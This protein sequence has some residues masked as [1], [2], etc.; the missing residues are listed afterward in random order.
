MPEGGLETA[1]VLL[2]GG[3]DSSVALA[4]AV[5]QGYRVHALTLDYGQRHSRELEAAT[6]VAAHYGVEHKVVRIDLTAFGGS[7]LTDAAI[8]VPKDTPEGEI[9][10][11]IPPTYVPARNTVFLSLALA[12]A[13]ALDADAIFI[14]ANSVD[15]SGYPDCRPEYLDAMQ[16]VAD[17]GTRRGV[18]GRPV[19]IHAP[20][21]TQS[22][23]AIV[24]RGLELGAPLHLTWT[25]YE[26]GA[27]ACGRC[28]SCQLRL[29]GFAQAGAVDPVE[30]VPGAARPDREATSPTGGEA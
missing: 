6:A 28:E 12:W 11:G 2:S 23:A 4:I 24:S 26:G 15:Y 14:G 22:K 30:Y 25:C 21:L 18:A 1:V 10:G 27:M 8:G 9:G 7:A 17:L 29:R 19:S 3:L 16:R 13:E 20:V 5:D